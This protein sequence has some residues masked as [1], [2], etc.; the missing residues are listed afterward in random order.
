MLIE[1][2][3]TIITCMQQQDKKNLH[4]L[5]QR[6]KKLRLKKN[7]SLNSFVMTRGGLTTASWSRL[8]N[9]K[10]D[11]KFSTLIKAAAML[12]IDV[13]ELLSGLHFGYEINE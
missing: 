1:Y 10:F 6:V 4:I 8:E 9:G 5:G 11:L 7:S 2:Y 3:N 12:E 13:C